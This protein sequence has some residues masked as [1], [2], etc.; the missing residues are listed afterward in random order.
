MVTREAK[1]QFFNHFYGVFL[2]S[3]PEI[4][5]MFLN[6]DFDKQ[7]A[8][9]KHAITMAIMF[10]ER[11]DDLARDVLTKISRTHSHH[12]LNVK[13]EYYVFWIKSII[14]TLWACDP[15]FD[16]ELEKDWKELLQLTVDFVKS[17]Y[18][19]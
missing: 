6:T 5:P 14:E 16:H 13:P 18:D 2:D 15:Q 17:G 8:M 10:A 9:L 1:E 7:I 11:E 4:G 19:Q 12:K 3:H